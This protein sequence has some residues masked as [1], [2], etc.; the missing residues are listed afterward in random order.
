M[1]IVHV[2]VQF[3][4]LTTK[5]ASSLVLNVRVNTFYTLKSILYELKKMR[6]N[7]NIYV[8]CT[9]TISIATMKPNLKYKQQT[10]FPKHG[11]T[12][13]SSCEAH[14]W[15]LQDRSIVDLIAKLIFNDC[16]GRK[17]NWYSFVIS[18]KSVFSLSLM[19]LH[20]FIA[21]IQPVFEFL[22]LISIVLQ[23]TYPELSAD[24]LF[25][26]F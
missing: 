18:W 10:P 3:I 13:N 7:E 22:G 4:S 20:N 9:F 12:I 15:C 25:F 11:H 17:F 19:P 5:K 1:S 2:H 6:S 21:I 8:S 26:L 24:N 16:L 14:V 23:W